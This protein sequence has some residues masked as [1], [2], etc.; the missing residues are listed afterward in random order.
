M[1]NKG[2]KTNLFSVLLYLFYQH[3]SMVATKTQSKQ[4][5]CFLLL[6]ININTLH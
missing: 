5:F 1:F 2:H 6:Y 4:I 3:Q